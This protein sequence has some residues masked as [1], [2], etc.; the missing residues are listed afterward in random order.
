MSTTFTGFRP[1]AFGFLVELGLNNDRSW[2]TPHKAEYE[3][4][5]KQPLEQLC[6]ALDEAFRARGLPLSA[7]PK[8]SPFRIHRDVRF[9]KDKSPYKINIGASFPWAGNGGGVGGYFHLE[10][11]E[12]FAGGG[13]YHPAPARLT[14][15]REKVVTDR[16]LVRAVVADPAFAAVFGRVYG[17]ALKRAPAGYSP[18]DPDIELLRLK[19]VIFRARMTD[20]ETGSPDLPELLAERLAASVPLLGLLAA[21]PGHEERAPWLR[22]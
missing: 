22:D 21:L 7:D 14:A 4:L 17:D 3:A 18:E 9:S 5:L 19:D 6:V 15:W 2:F 11:G 8:R 20:E 1:E 12:T 16:G 10:P 13:M